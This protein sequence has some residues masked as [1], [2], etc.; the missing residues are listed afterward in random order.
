VISLLGQG[1]MGVVYQAYQ[2]ALNRLVALKMILAAGQAGEEQLARFHTE[3]EALARLQHP[4]IVQIHEIGAHEGRPYIALEYVDG[5]SLARQLSG[6]PW[7]AGRAAEMVE[8]LARAIHH[9]HGRGIVHRD[10]TPANVLLTPAGLPRITDFGLAKLLVGGGPTLTQTGAIL[11]TPS[12]MAPEQAA[13]K[14]QEVGPATDVYALGAILYELLTGRPPFKAETPLDTLV[15]VQ[16]QEPVSPSRLQPKLPRDL[17]TICL[18]CLQKEP[19]RRY[20]SAEALAED[21]RRFRAG[22]PIRARPIGSTERLW[23]WCRRNPVVATLT[24]FVAAL[25]M[26]IAAG[27]MLAA[28]RFR[29]DRDRAE[30]AEGEAKE[31]LWESY[32]E[33][34]RAL[35][36]SRRPGQRIQSLLAI[37]EAMQLPLP[38]GHSLDELRTE[39]IAALAVPDVE[40]VREW[41][42]YPTGSIGLDFDGKVERYARLATDGT[43]SVR[44]VSDDGVLAHWQ[45]RTEGPWPYD[46]SNLRFSPDGRFL[47]VRHS[48]SGRLSVLRLDGPEPAVCHRETRGVAGSWAMDFS[49]D[50]KQLAYLLTDTRIAVV[51]LTSR[52][53]NYLKPTGVGQDC[54]QFAPDGRRFAVGI[55]PPG[56]WTIEVRDA[57]TGQVQQSLP[58]P[59]AAGHP[60][61]HPDGR[62]LATCC[63]DLRIRLWDVGSGQPFRVLKGHRSRGIRC[64]FTR[65]GDRLVSNDWDGVLQIWEPASGKQLLSFPANGYQILRISPD[66]RIP[67]LHF[68]D[69][70]KLQLLRLHPGVGYRTIGLDGAAANRALELNAWPRVHPRGRLLAA[71]A[72]DGS[73]A[74]VDLGAGRTVATLPI[75]RGQPLFW[76]PAGELLTYGTFGLLRW[77]VDVRPAE[78]ERYSFGPPERLLEIGV[79]DL[80]GSTADGQ[81]LAIPNYNCG[82]VV[83]H[84][85]PPARRVRLRPQQDVRRCSVSPDGRW[86]AT[87]SHS[88]PDGRGVKVWEAATGNLVQ[89]LPV[90][91]SCWAAFSPDPDGRWL[92]TTGGGCRVWEVGSWNEWWKVGGWAG[93]FSPDGQFLA[94]ADSPGVIRLV[95][96]EDRAE[97][98][99][100]EAPERTRLVP[101]CFTLDGTQLIAV[102]LDT[103]ALHVWDLP[104]IRRE[105]APIGLDWDAL[106]YPLGPEPAAVPAPLT[107]TVDMGDLLRKRK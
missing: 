75:A 48:T 41:E 3:A 91:G 7:P 36:M 90:P 53:T 52:K 8:T 6:T 25:L 65:T 85:R 89:A 80:W 19:A 35:R 106:P 9:A 64:A 20:P 70:T 11:G 38:P 107:V 100:L 71:T 95:R 82:A 59:K 96:P 74:L 12:Y 28:L 103:G 93:C 63:D 102:G 72:T 2:R 50:S 88:N 18:K 69:W 32:R 92:L 42:G 24:G 4:N 51:D 27:S 30:R 62:T 10:L 54:I 57:A 98:T 45:E 23:R 61:W 76:A 39:A 34:A 1:G 47:C 49:P 94:V 78:P 60:A 46:E 84:R 14:G 104:A 87:G 73:L 5:S 81:T 17:A 67:A 44:R 15:Q 79:N 29:A 105:L 99:R 97:L 66:N 31:K 40:M 83:V 37:E 43:V 33:K 56:R 58:H 101:R 13:G 26:F 86:V 21:L 68:T 77:P 16:S 55:R 22:E